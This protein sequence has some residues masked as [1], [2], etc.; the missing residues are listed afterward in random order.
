[1]S[2]HDEWLSWTG[3]GRVTLGPERLLGSLGWGDQADLDEQGV[4]QVLTFIDVGREV[5]DEPEAAAIES[6]LKE[7]EGSRGVDD[8]LGLGVV[9]RLL[10]VEVVAFVDAGEE[11]VVMGDEV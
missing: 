4:E 7:E 6:T 9:V 11:L 8:A 3:E 5:L 10:E 1:V 2:T